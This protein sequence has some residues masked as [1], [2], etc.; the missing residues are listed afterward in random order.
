MTDRVTYTREFGGLQDSWSCYPLCWGDNCFLFPKDPNNVGS[1]ALPTLSH[2]VESQYVDCWGLT[3][4][5]SQ[6]PKKH[7]DTN[8]IS[9]RWAFLPAK[10]VCFSCTSRPWWSILH[11]STGMKRTWWEKNC[12][13]AWMPERCTGIYNTIL[14]NLSQFNESHVRIVRPRKDVTA[15]A[16]CTM[17]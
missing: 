10:S 6:S 9:R 16:S 14:F 3:A 11:C 5:E 7:Q 2:T 12:G 13:F 1:A 15:T 4:W 17:L 8:S